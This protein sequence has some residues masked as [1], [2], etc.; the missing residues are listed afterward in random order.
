MSEP[1]TEPQLAD[2]AAL[3]TRLRIP[4]GILDR[5]CADRFGRPFARIDKRQATALLDEVIAWK[6]LPAPY[7]RAMGQTDVPGC[8]V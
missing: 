4:D 3:Q 7:Q 2:I 1:P 5:I 6:T 8:D